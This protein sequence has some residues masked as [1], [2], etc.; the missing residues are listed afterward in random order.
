MDMMV[1]HV[2]QV[3]MG[4]KNKDTIVIGDMPW[5]AYETERQAVENAR[6]PIAHGG[7]PLAKVEGGRE[8]AHTVRGNCQ[9]GYRG[10]GAFGV[11]A[12]DWKASGVWKE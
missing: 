11:Y 9:C 10:N 7:Q 8:K 1:R 2:Q 6:R 4:V 5:L 12:A 3:R